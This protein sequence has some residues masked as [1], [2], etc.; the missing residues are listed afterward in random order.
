MPFGGLGFSGML[1]ST[2]WTNDST[3]PFGADRMTFTYLISNA[4]DSAHVVDRLTISSYA[5][6]MADVSY[7]PTGTGVPPAQADRSTADVIGFNFVPTFG[8]G[9]ILPGSDSRLLVVQTDSTV[10]T[11]SI[12]SAINGGVS[13][14]PSFAPVPEPATW[15][16][17]LLGL[18]GWYALT[19]RL[20]K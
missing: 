2:V 10:F 5:G 20:R 4:A 15:T 9:P 3:N 6:F 18:A 12:A 8:D 17:A 13:M 16:L 14:M 1:T 7:T 19:R 11:E